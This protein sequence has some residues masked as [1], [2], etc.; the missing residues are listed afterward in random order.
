MKTLKFEIQTIFA[1]TFTGHPSR[2][3]EDDIE[4]LKKVCLILAERFDILYANQ[5][6]QKP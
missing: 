6:G 4:K 3:D 2:E 1:E 5:E